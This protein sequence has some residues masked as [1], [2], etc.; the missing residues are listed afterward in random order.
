MAGRAVYHQPAWKRL[1]KF[2]LVRDGYLCKIGLPGC[3][4]A[5]TAVDHI[6]ELADGGP[7]LDARNLQAACVT[8]NSG[9]ANKRRPQRDRGE[10]LGSV[11]DW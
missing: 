6:V 9:K 1:R 11:R 3:R 5:A 10:P 7:A 8:C 2:V 4:G